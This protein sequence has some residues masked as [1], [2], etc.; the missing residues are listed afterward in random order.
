MKTSKVLLG[1]AIALIVYIGV[2]S[3]GFFSNIRGSG[4]VIKE[5]RELA[6]FHSIEVGGAFKVHITQGEPQKVQIE[7]DDNIM[8]Q[9]ITKVKGGDLKIYSKGSI[10]NPT[11]LNIDIVVANLDDIDIS[12][13]CK[14]VATNIFTSNKMDIDCS[15]ASVINMGLQCKELG[16]DI[17]GASVGE[18]NGT[19]KILS[20]EASGASNLKC[21]NLEASIA[22]VEASGASNVS[23]SADKII[24][25]E[26]SGSSNVDYKS[27]GASLEINTSGVS[28]VRKR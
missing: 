5:T 10:S 8:P 15:G 25:I 21:Q 23:I 18:F 13:A 27:N 19:T 1:I 17:S 11:K 12:G 6:V 20:I 24:N 9:I 16:I 22:D 7:T 4:N 3:F 2:T 26:A 14:L 28:H